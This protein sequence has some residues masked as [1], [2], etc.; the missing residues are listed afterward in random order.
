MYRLIFL[1]GKMKGRRLAVR[2]G[3]IVIGRDPACHVALE[4]DES[5][6]PRHASIEERG[7]SHFL[8][9]FDAAHALQVNGRPVVEAVL[10]NG[11]K[12][13]V[14]RTQLEFHLIY[15]QSPVGE[16]RSISGLQVLTLLVIAGIVAA[17]IY[18]VVVAPMRQKTPKLDAASLAAVRK[19]ALAKKQQSNAVPVVVTAT[20]NPEMAQARAMIDAMIAAS[21]SVPTA[22]FT[23][24]IPATAISPP[25]PS[26]VAPPSPTVPV[27][28]PP[29]NDVARQNALVETSAPPRAVTPTPVEPAEDPVV[30]EAKQMLQAALARAAAGDLPQA[31]TALDRIQFMAPDFLPAYTERAKILEK[32][33]R[34]RDAA[35]QWKEVEKRAAGTP[36]ASAAKS[37]Q[38]RMAALE[39]A[40]KNSAVA[41]AKAA[42]VAAASRPLRILSIERERF[43]STRDYDEMRVLRIN[44]LQNSGEAINPADVGVMVYFFDR[45]IDNDKI[46]L[47]RA[48]VPEKVLRLDGRWP[49]GESKSVTATYVV[50]QNF[51][52]EELRLQGQHCVYAGHRVQLFYKGKLVDEDASPAELLNA[53]LV[54][55]VTK[56]DADAPVGR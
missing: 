30:A 41:A 32:L 37:E 13:D 26:P 44:L 23:S 12:I 15:D 54:K 17:E 18:F 25:P 46:A 20:N 35:A 21:N 5:V 7:G 31:D 10:K 24:P 42:A 56:T 40:A 29:S 28:V 9:A 50:P 38:E 51:R 22:V 19:A 11:D 14:G 33:G 47:T 45:N 6:A 34:Y 4:D 27:I 53:P 8:C 36:Q 48:V 43:Q 2:E 39:T 1:N 16:K 52:N 49:P 55:P 3:S